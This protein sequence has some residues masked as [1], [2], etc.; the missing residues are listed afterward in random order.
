MVVRI[1]QLK[2]KTLFKHKLFKRL[3]EHFRTTLILCISLNKIFIQMA[4]PYIC[5]RIL[6]PL[7]CLQF[8]QNNWHRTRVVSRHA[9]HKIAFFG[10]HKEAKGRIHYKCHRKTLFYMTAVRI[11]FQN[12]VSHNLSVLSEQSRNV[13]I[14]S[15]ILWSSVP[16]FDTLILSQV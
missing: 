14:S 16:L 7:L 10:S 3:N 5:K 8:I 4:K 11:L 1:F 2:N 13:L 9:N 6:S 12:G 15:F